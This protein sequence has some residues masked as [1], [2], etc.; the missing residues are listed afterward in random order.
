MCLLIRILSLS[1]HVYHTVE[2]SIRDLDAA[3]DICR[4]WLDGQESTM[5]S[6]EED[7]SSDQ[8]L[9]NGHNGHNGLVTSTHSRSVLTYFA[10]I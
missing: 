1:L 7:D 9:H 6:D 3:V 2:C 8:R 10:M 5:W 4:G